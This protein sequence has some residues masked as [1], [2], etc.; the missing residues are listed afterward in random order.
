M[1]LDEDRT[2]SG[3]K[4]LARTDADCLY[5]LDGIRNRPG[6]DLQPGLAERTPEKDD[7]IG[8][9]PVTGR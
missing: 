2:Q 6:P 9:T 8:K 1:P 7:I 4:F 3:V 5:R